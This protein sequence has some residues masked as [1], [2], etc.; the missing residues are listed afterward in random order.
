MKSECSQINLVIEL[1][2]KSNNS[3]DEISKGW[4]NARKVFQ[5]KNM[6]ENNL[7]NEIIEKF[8]NLEYWKDKGSPHFSPSEG[9]FCNKCKE[10]I[11]FP[12]KN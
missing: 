11:Y 2:L 7:K 5:M 10:G 12:A 9:F 6:L 4:S 1:C 8:P 3:V